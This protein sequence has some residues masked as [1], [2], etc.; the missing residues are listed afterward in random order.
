MNLEQIVTREL[1]LAFKLADATERAKRAAD[2]A[3]TAL[4][5]S[6]DSTAATRELVQVSSEIAA[7]KAA[8]RLNR[9]RR[10][11]AIRDKRAADAKE[12][13]AQAAGLRERITSIAEVVR[14]AIETINAAEETKVAIT[15]LPTQP[16]PQTQLL[17]THAQNL[18]NRAIV[19]EIDPLPRSGNVDV[20]DTTDLTDLIKAVLNF[21]ADS[22]N[23]QE[24]T[25]WALAVEARGVDD[26]AS[27][28]GG[29]ARR[30]FGD[31]PRNFHLEWKDGQI[32][33][34]ASSI[35]VSALARRPVGPLGGVGWEFGSDTFRATPQ[36]GLFCCHP[37]KLTRLC[38]LKPLRWPGDEASAKRRI[39][40]LPI[41]LAL[42]R[43]AHSECR[44]VRNA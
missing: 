21:P 6:T 2:A 16:T 15:A 3:G 23:A 25:D 42:R 22:P 4:L 36:R 8:L 19:F 30:T 12:L 5:D 1:E 13:R 34:A 38:P 33:P 28:Y 18:C 17:E 40:R 29:H 44:A 37:P 32:D 14:S 10:L 41:W 27:T 20:Q 39:V 24:I 11:D 7:T 35:Q 26:G 9:L 43:N 31:H